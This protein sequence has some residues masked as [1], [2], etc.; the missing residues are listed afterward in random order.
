[1]RA[2]NTNIRLFA[3]RNDLTVFGASSLQLKYQRMHLAMLITRFAFGLGPSKE[4]PFPGDA[5]GALRVLESSEIVKTKR[6]F[7]RFWMTRAFTTDCNAPLFRAMLTGPVNWTKMEIL[8][9]ISQL[10]QVIKN[11]KTASMA[12]FKED[13]VGKTEWLKTLKKPLQTLIVKEWRKAR[14]L[15]STTEAESELPSTGC[16]PDRYR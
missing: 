11:R 1:M 5:E 16:L 6:S 15:A 7:M 14:S 3:I 10:S 12:R 8:S 13:V 4:F 2:T 9:F